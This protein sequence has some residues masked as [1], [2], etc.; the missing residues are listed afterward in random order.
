LLENIITMV[1]KTLFKTLP[2]PCNDRVVAEK[3][4]P[5]LINLPLDDDVLF[6]NNI[7]DWRLMKE[8]LSR[9]GPVTKV[10]CMRI[11]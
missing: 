10:Q 9:E 2:N 11:L 5:A 7:P 6:K 4:C 8:L 3:D 1:E